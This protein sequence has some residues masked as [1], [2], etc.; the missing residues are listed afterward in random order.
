MEEQYK[1]ELGSIYYRMEAV[2]NLQLL[3]KD[4][5]REL[6][7]GKGDVKE[8]EFKSKHLRVY[9]IHQKDGKIVVMGGYKNSQDKDIVTFRALKKQYIESLNDKKK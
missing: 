3:P 6:K 2:A 4:K 8:Y 1:S 9:A 7:G 5:F